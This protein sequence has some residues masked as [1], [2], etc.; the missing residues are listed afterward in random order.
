MN[1]MFSKPFHHIMS[2]L[3]IPSLLSAIQIISQCHVS[4]I[5]GLNLSIIYTIHRNTQ[6][7]SVVTE[8]FIN[9]ALFRKSMILCYLVLAQNHQYGKFSQRNL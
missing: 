7:V 2:N 3:Y 8:Y 4:L 1:I 6:K 5:T 9:M